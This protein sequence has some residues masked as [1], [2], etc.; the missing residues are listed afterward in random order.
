MSVI[1]KSVVK[2]KYIFYGI[3]ELPENIHC[4]KDLDDN[5]QIESWGIKWGELTINWK[6]GSS[7]TIEASIPIDETNDYKYPSDK[8]EDYIFS[9]ISD[10]EFL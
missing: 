7:T 9:E 3:F 1:K 6:D 10:N 2:C 5:P 8:P 4:L